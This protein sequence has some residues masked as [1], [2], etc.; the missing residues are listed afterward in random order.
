MRNFHA[1][2]R[3]TRMKL[4]VLTSMAIAKSSPPGESSRTY[5]QHINGHERLSTCTKLEDITPCQSIVRENSLAGNP[6]V[7]TSIDTVAPLP[8]CLL[9]SPKTEKDQGHESDG[10]FLRRCLRKTSLDG[11]C[12]GQIVPCQRPSREHSFS[13][14]P[15]PGASTDFISSRTI[16]DKYTHIG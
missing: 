9:V 1:V 8:T 15:L 7:L 3:T 2:S 10:D 5:S 4:H 14:N 12:L 13:G 16:F 11:A 6:L